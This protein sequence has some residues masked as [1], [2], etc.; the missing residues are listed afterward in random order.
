MKRYIGQW[1]VVL[2]H[3]KSWWEKFL[4]GKYRHAFLAIVHDGRL[5]IAENT[6]LGFHITKDFNQFKGEQVIN[7]KT[8]DIVKLPLPA[9]GISD[10]FRKVW[11]QDGYNSFTSIARIFHMKDW[12][13]CDG[14]DI[15]A[16]SI[17]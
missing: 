10:S 15:F 5:A 4:F 9:I 6:I 2:I 7:K 16:S 1:D 12:E 8:Y 3:S 17:L 14:E 11:G 13:T